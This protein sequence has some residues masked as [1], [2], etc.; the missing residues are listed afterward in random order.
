VQLARV[1]A[2]EEYYATG[3]YTSTVFDAGR[4][5]DWAWAHWN[6]S[7]LPQGVAVEWRTGNTP[8][9]DAGWSAWIPP[10]WG[11]PESYCVVGTS[12]Q[13]TECWSH[14]AGVPN[15]RY[16]QYRGAFDTDDSR[17][18]VALWDITITYGLHYPEGTAVSI[19][20]S[21]VDLR[22]WQTVVYSATIPSGA[23]LQVDILDGTGDCDAP[24][25][26]AQVQPGES[27]EAI[28]PAQFRSLRLRA[29]LR[30]TD[31]SLSPALDAWGLR[32]EVGGRLYMPLLLQER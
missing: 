22:A 21:P 14:L 7:G 30:T 25:L 4:P 24:M 15:A 26:L 19:P 6:Y 17:H 31:P 1:P 29:T 20:L 12:L 2:T 18:T 13:A 10:A 5:V 27:L 28:D 32:W 16:A 11:A 23:T 8:H 9:P 3:V